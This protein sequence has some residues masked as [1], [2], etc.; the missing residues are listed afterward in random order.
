MAAQLCKIGR[1]N[2]RGIFSKSGDDKHVQQG[3]QGSEFVLVS[4][5]ENSG[6][7]I[8]FNRSDVNQ[9]QL[10]K[11]AIRAGISDY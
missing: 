8:T 5:S 1:I 6:R 4:G 11:G 10:G 3:D 2:S 7:E 9:I